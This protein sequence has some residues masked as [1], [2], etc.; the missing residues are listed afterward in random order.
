MRH[1]IQW[2]I[3]SRVYY[4]SGQSL[5]YLLTLTWCLQV[6]Y[7]T[8]PYWWIKTALQVMKSKFNCQEPIHKTEQIQTH[9][10]DFMPRCWS[11]QIGNRPSVE[12]ALDFLEEAISTGRGL[13]HISLFGNNPVSILIFVPW[14]RFPYLYNI[15]FSSVETLGGIDPFRAVLEERFVWSQ[16]SLI[17]SRSQTIRKKR[18]VPS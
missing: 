16:I 14:C 6:L 4:A 3:F 17:V 2:Y 7:G 11:V 1:Q 5:I 8:L 15:N 9:H 10:L 13:V 12:K 18:V